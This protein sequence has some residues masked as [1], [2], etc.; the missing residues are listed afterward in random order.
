MPFPGRSVFQVG[1][2]KFPLTSTSG[3]DLIVDADPLIFHWLQFCKSVITTHLGNRF[4]QAATAANLTGADG[5]LITSPVKQLV[6]YSPA[7]YLQEVQFKFPL[8]SADRFNETYKEETRQWYE[9][10][11]QMQMLYMLPPLT[12]AQMYKLN[13]FR[14]NVTK[15][16]LDRLELGWDPSYNNGELIFKTA[17]IE[18]IKFVKSDYLGLENPANVKTFFPTVMM[19][20]DVKERKNHIDGSFP[21]LTSI[22][23][24]TEIS[25]GNQANNYDMIDWQ[26]DL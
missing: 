14:S 18:E 22:N 19:T 23:G 25:D 6:P 7:D 24:S 20:F 15:V 16:L 8:L 13:S 9:I 5:N 1:G 4:A 3:N 17:G 10:S 21:D 26:V 11:F 12:A 2:V